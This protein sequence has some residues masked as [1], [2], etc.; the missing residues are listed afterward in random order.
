MMV[1][2]ELSKDAEAYRSRQKAAVAAAR[3]RLAQEESSAMELEDQRASS[4]RR[5][6]YRTPEQDFIAWIDRCLAM[7]KEITA[8]T[9]SPKTSSTAV[10][11][12]Q[13]EPQ[14]NPCCSG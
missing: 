4:W 2:D 5:L 14:T 8:A 12:K 7:S 6:N 10:A 1:K 9:V 11:V 13:L 3:E